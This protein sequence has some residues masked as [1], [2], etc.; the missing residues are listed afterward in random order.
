MPETASWSGFVREE[1]RGVLDSVLLAF[2][3]CGSSC[4]YLT[5][6]LY[7]FDRDNFIVLNPFLALM[8]LARN[9]RS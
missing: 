3:P 6:H 4:S 5:S 1:S 7:V 8:V 9:V 2:T